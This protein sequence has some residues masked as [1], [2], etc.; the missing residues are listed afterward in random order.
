M[1]NTF[2]YDSRLGIPLPV[3]TESWENLEPGEQERILGEWET[4]RGKI[5]SRVKEIEI[6]I[7]KK[8]QSLD[9]EENFVQS[10]RLNSEIADLASIIN[11]LWIWYR[12]SNGLSVHSR[13]H[14]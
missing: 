5:P 14:A 4:I 8:Q 3:L 1:K 11:D 2:K 7:E 13:L 6:Q 10:C 12:E 9:E